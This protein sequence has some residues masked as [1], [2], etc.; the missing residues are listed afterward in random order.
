MSRHSRC[1]EV[2][3]TAPPSQDGVVAVAFVSASV[4]LL[5]AGF[6]VAAVQAAADGTTTHSSATTAHP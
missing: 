2:H 4:V 5:V 3:R 1:T 6:P